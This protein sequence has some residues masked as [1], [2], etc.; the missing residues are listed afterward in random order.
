MRL[1]WLTELMSPTGADSEQVSACSLL[2]KRQIVIYTLTL[3]KGDK[4]NC[5]KFIVDQSLSDS[6]FIAKLSQPQLGTAQEKD[7]GLQLQLTAF[8]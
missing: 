4:Q 5:G 8:S 6:G 1:S 2:A 7:P 3:S